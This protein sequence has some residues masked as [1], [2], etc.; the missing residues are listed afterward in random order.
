VCV[1]ETLQHSNTVSD[2]NRE[3]VENSSISEFQLN[4]YLDILFYSLKIYTKTIIR[5]MQVF[6]WLLKIPENK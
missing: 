6:D 4:R 5:L 2:S 3:Q 1:Q